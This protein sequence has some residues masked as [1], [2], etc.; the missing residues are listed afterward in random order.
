MPYIA[1]D[2]TVGA[3]KSWLRMVQDMFASVWS[4]I[5]LFFVT[6]TNPKAIESKAGSKRTFAQRNG[7]KSYRDPS[8]SYG[9]GQQL[10]RR[11]GANIRGVRD[12]GTVDC[13]A[14]GG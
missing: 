8:G 11:P 7:G 2:G 5:T 3:K 9:G 13:A 14:G 4:L 1:P 10:G 6:I 12:L